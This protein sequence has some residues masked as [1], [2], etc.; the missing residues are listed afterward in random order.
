MNAIRAAVH[1][2]RLEVEVPADWP[3]GIEVMIE[4]M[5]ESESLGIREEDWQ[6]TPEAIEQWLRWYDSLEP[7]VMT[8]EEEA[9]WEAARQAQKEYQK[10]T[11]VEHAETLRRMWE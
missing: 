7:L 3:D 11:F 6:N 4:P 2:H 10:A 5:C 1:N 8:P 9:E